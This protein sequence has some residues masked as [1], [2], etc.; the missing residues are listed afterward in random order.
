MTKI[1]NHLRIDAGYSIADVARMMHV[2]EHTACGWLCGRAYPTA[3]ER[4]RLAAIFSVDPDLLLPGGDAAS[5][6]NDKLR[7]RIYT[8]GGRMF[9]L[10]Q[11][12]RRRARL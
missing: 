11:I 10:D 12:T 3:D 4:A 9:H 2:D 5:R 8:A 6:R 7:T 1:L